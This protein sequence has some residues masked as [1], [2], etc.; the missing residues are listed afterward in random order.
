MLVLIDT[1]SGR[2][3]ILGGGAYASA[4]DVQTILELQYANELRALQ[5]EMCELPP[6]RR[7]TLERAIEDFQQRYEDLT[8]KR[9][10]L[11]PCRD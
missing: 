11:V 8:G 7:A 3:I 9:Y 6:E 10:P 5:K 1:L 4:K 2:G